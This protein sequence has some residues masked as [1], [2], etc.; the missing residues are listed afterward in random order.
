LTWS[1][2][3]LAFFA[4]RAIDP[5]I[6]EAAGVKQNG[7]G[8]V[9]PHNR[10]RRYDGH[11]MQSNGATV[12]PWRVIEDSWPG[13]RAALITEGETDGLAA[14]TALAASPEAPGFRGLP[15]LAIPGC[16]YS[17]Q[18]IARGLVKYGITEAYIAFD[19]DEPG[20]KAAQ[21]LANALAQAR[22]RP[23]RAEPPQG[24]IADWLCSV[25]A[26]GEA[27]ASH[28]ADAQPFETGPPSF[29]SVA[30]GS[31]EWIWRE[32]IPLRKL[33]ILAGDPK[34]GKS[35]LTCLLAA[36]VAKAGHRVLMANVD[37][38]PGDV[39]RRLVAL[40]A[41]FKRIFPMP[42]FILPRGLP[43]LRRAI[44]E[45]EA[46]L[47]TID[48]WD[49]FCDVANP[50]RR[51]EIYRALR[52]LQD[53]A[54]ENDCAVVVVCHANR[55]GEDQNPIY[56]IPVGLRDIS[57]AILSLQREGEKVKLQHTS[58]YGEQPPLEYRFDGERLVDKAADLPPAPSAEQLAALGLEAAD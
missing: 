22:V 19:A 26:P 21:A 46:K 14:A 17:P 23:L 34:Q 56:R 48:P 43:E 49:S 29:A 55:P 9:Y 20:R 7:S 50:N 38:D 39:K 4:E 37:D 1:S 58:T 41:D 36:E 33:T 8:L 16:Q 52:P 6:A 32:R 2:E 44:V 5:A 18:V 12:R 35:L 31:I 51:Q 11:T 27:L 40:D 45:T 15:I 57:R 3:A 28:L 54:A 53:L 30:A 10:T 13:A 25:E 42:H 47:V 24:D